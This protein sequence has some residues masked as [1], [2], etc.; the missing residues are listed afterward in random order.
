M[1]NIERFKNF[2]VRSFTFLYKNN[3]NFC[4]LLNCDV[5][6]YNNKTHISL[7]C[8]Y[9]YRVNNFQLNKIYIF[10]YYGNCNK[11]VNK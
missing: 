5:T 1:N 9:L 4:N 7:Y 10:I 8:T 6:L 3:S 2:N 11:L